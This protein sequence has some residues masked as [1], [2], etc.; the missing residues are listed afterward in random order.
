MIYLNIKSN[1]PNQSV[2]FS[3]GTNSYR[4]HLYT[5]KGFTLADVYLNNEAVVNGARCVPDQLIV[6]NESALTDGNFAFICVD[7]DYPYYT[8]FN[9]SQQLVFLTAQEIE[10][11]TI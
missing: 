2:N 7:K 11:F 3:Y 6:Q 9:R 4:I 10:S 1:N 8:K 5:F